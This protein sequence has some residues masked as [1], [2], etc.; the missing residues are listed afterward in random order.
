MIC[1]Y[2]KKEVN[3]LSN[4]LAV[5]DQCET[6]KIIEQLN[7]IYELNL[8]YPVFMKKSEYLKPF[9]II[10]ADNQ[11]FRIYHIEKDSKSKLISVNARHIFYDLASYFVEDRRSVDKTCLDAM[12]MVIEEVGLQGV[13]TVESNITDLLTQYLI[14][15][16]AAEAMFILANKYRGELV[17]DNFHIRIRDGSPNDKGVL[18]EYGKNVLGIN[19]KINGDK[20]LT[21]IYPVGSD[22]LTLP[23]KYLINALWEG[24]EYPD[25]K[26]I[27]RVDFKDIKDVD[28]LRQE[29]GNYLNKHASFGVNYQ[30]DFI[31][32]EHTTEYERYKKLLKVKVG[33]TVTVRH[34]LMMI[35]FK[36]QVISIETDLLSAKNTKVELGIPLYTLNKYIEEMKDDLD[37]SIDKVDSS[38]GGIKEQLDNL[39]VSYTIV[40]ELAINETHINVIY[41]VEKG[42]THEY[43]ANYSY[44]TDSQGRFTSIS[45]EDIFSELLLKEVASLSVDMTKFYIVYSDRTTAEYNYTTDSVGRITSVSRVQGG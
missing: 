39:G 6:C 43:H 37:S 15:K 12:N 3:F 35:D 41:E 22:N 19:E 31:Q 16:N 45:L 44:T 32:L 14:K 9:N 23:E 13:Y 10:K 5:L 8:S 38:L 40:R 25:F 2:D 1:I 26:M 7:G 21:G 42:D 29:A 34:K 30:V 33:D 11:L 36:L 27:K 18:I 17:R 20:V 4:G 28:T 24:E